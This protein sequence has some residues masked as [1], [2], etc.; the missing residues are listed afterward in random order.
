MYAIAAGVAVEYSEVSPNTGSS[1]RLLVQTTTRSL[2][3]MTARIAA[4]VLSVARWMRS[5]VK[6]VPRL[7]TVNGA[8]DADYV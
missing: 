7:L 1:N 2:R 8:L 4:S 6:E 5:S 3:R